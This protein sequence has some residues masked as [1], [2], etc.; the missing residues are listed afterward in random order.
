MSLET[1]LNEMSISLGL[2]MLWN[3]HGFIFVNVKERCMEK[4]DCPFKSPSGS[5]SQLCTVKF[6]PDSFVC[7]LPIF[8]FCFWKYCQ[9]LWLLSFLI[10][11]CSCTLGTLNSLS[12]NHIRSPILDLKQEIKE[13]NA[14]LNCL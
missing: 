4:I 3:I 7:H 2:Y 9:K 10:V 14:I 1:I 11:C 13:I 6:K 12:P 8:F 5:C